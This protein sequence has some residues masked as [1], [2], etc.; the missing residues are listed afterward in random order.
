MKKTVSKNKKES[1]SQAFLEL[2]VSC[3]LITAAQE[4]EILP[5][6]LQ[7]SKAHPSASVSRFLIKHRL[8]SKDQI[9]FLYSV[10]RHLDMLMADKRFGKLGIAN[11]LVTPEKVKKALNLQVEIFKKRKKSIKIGDILVQSRDMTVADKTA[12]LLTQDRIKDELLAE[13]LNV[14]SK[15][16]IERIDMGK[17][18]GAIAVKK[19]FITTDQL[20]RALKI[21]RKERNQHQAQRVLGEIF[22]EEFDLTGK[23]ILEI[24]RIQKKLEIKRLNLEEKLS[25]YNAQ[26]TSNRML[27]EYF[28]Y[29]VTDDKMAAYVRKTQPIDMPVSVETFLNWFSLSGIKHGLCGSKKIR[30][31]IGAGDLSRPLKI[32][33]GT[34]AIP[35]KNE[36][37]EYHFD[38]NC[39]ETLPFQGEDGNDRGDADGPASAPVVKK[40]DLLATVTP[41]EDSVRGTDVFGRPVKPPEITSVFLNAGQGVVRQN[42][43]F[44]ALVTGYPLL[45][46]GRTLFVSPVRRSL[47][48]HEIDGDVTKETTETFHD[49]NLNIRGNI[50]P[51]THVCCHNLSIEGDI[52]GSVTATGNIDIRGSIGD[53]DSGADIRDTSLVT[54]KG[55]I[56][57]TKRI[58]NAK[59]EAKQG[60]IAPN[61]DLISS[62]ILSCRNI[63]LNNIISSRNAPSILRVTRENT[64]EIERIERLVS[65]LYKGKDK[66]L[67]KSDLDKLSAELM[68]QVQVQ[69][70]YLEK[71]N[72]VLYLNRIVN[73]SGLDHINDIHEKIKAVEQDPRKIDENWI[74][75]PEHTKAH[76][77]MEMII[78]KIKDLDR[79]DQQGYVKEIHDN[80]S[81]LYKAAVKATERINKNYEA[82]TEAVDALVSNKRIQVEKIQT[83]IDSLNS[84]KD[85]LLHEKNRADRLDLPVIKVKN[86]VGRHTIILGEKAKRVVTE[87]IYRVSLQE[88]KP[89]NKSDAKFVVRGFYE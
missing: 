24:L 64:L 56:L 74:S 53:E 82:M 59:I 66:L 79:V 65:A 62:R 18:F 63:E 37:V 81:G 86:Q 9:Q 57:I 73:D 14:I 61:S 88:T 46:E 80:I 23:E 10:K 19:Q 15:T 13:A 22:E 7:Y 77:F 43:S 28:E 89:I 78:E 49:C 45:F 12:L 75:I 40:G 55:S 27:D 6:L 41:S 58:I 29:H 42:N 36:S 54:A 5:K 31:F 70:G 17:R 39:Q 26:K 16:E 44:I 32:A 3:K 47:P 84:Q 35:F 34:D 20:N 25:E 68:E 11:R 33:G 1:K 51:G 85:F 50:T 83:K 52:M 76:R 71:Q 2:A 69:N 21:Q 4:K 38:T 67:H 48:T 8:L 30:A 87:P 72:A 60:L